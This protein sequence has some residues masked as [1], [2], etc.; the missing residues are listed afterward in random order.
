VIRGCASCPS[1]ARLRSVSSC[2]GNA[3]FIVFDDA[4]LSKAVDGAIAAKFRNIGQAYT[5]AHRFI[6]HRSVAAESTRRVTER[7]NGF[8]TGRGTENDVT[9]GPLIDGRAVDPT[10]ELIRDAVQRGATVL[11]GETALDRP[12]S[13]YSATVLTDVQFGSDILREE[14]FGPVLAIVPFDDEDEAVRIANDTEYGLVSYVYTQDLARGQRMIEVLQT[15][16]MGLNVGVVSNAAA[17]FGGWKFSGL[18]REGGAKGI[19]EYPQ[20]ECTLTPTPFGE[21]RRCC[22][23][24]LDTSFWEQIQQA[25]SR[26]EAH[27]DDERV[28]ESPLIHGLMI[29]QEQSLSTASSIADRPTITGTALHT[30][31]IAVAA[32]GFSYG[33]GLASPPVLATKIV[34]VPIAAVTGQLGRQSRRAQRARLKLCTFPTKAPASCT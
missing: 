6:A 26:H 1:P 24:E 19:Y 34:I 31:A 33:A 9:I 12:G 8:I 18:G 20:T 11:T 16:T 13:F 2:C 14:I 27:V 15:G 7:V 32:T 21:Q 28:H 5:A 23:I 29:P 17:P 25:T 3:P 30:G 22:F 10:D 4:D